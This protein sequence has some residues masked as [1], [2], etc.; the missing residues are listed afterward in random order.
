MVL[1]LVSVGVS[2]WRSFR[3]TTPSSKPGWINSVT[4]AYDQQTGA[5]LRLPSTFAGA[6]LLVAIVANDGPDS[7]TADTHAVFGGTSRLTWV[8]HAHISARQDWAAPGDSLDLAGASSAEIWTAT[9]PAGWTPGTVTE[10][11]DFPEINSPLRDDG[12]IITVA[13]WSTGQLG[14]I[15]T[16]DGLDSRLQRQSVDTLGPASTIYAAMFNGRANAVFTPV[17]GY[18][19][20][21][22]IVRRAGDDTAQVIASNDRNLPAGIQQVGYISTPAPGNYWEMAVVEVVPK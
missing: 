9:P 10:I 4:A 1:G 3:S 6:N 18:H 14:Q 17:A 15:F 7:N 22:G 21:A 13:A 2:P 12:G 19:S 20:A 11:S 16:L 8:R 5:S